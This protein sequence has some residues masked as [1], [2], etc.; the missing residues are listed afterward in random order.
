MKNI[1]W[2]KNL[3]FFGVRPG[4]KRISLLLKKLSHPH[5]KLKVIHL[6]GTNGKGSTA[7]IISKILEEHGFKVGLYTSPHLIKINERFLINDVPVSDEKLDFY[8]GRIK[9]ALG[10]DK[11]TYFEVTT[12]L[13]FLYFA[14]EKVDFAVIECGMGGRLD[15][16]NVLWPEVSVITTIGFDHQKFLGNTLDKIA[17]EKAG[18]M[19]RGVPCV[20]GEEKEETLHV[21][22][23]KAE[24]SKVPIFLFKKDFQIKLKNK[25]WYYFG[26]KVFKELDLSLQGFYQ[27]KNLAC[28][29]KT[30]E[31]LEDKGLFKIDENAL[32]DALKK[33]KNPGRYEKFYIKNK[34]IILD[35]AHNP[36]GI[37]ALVTSLKKDNFCKFIL[38][39]GI[40]NPY[41]DKD[42]LT[43][44]E[45]FFH[46]A[47]QV[48]ICE[49]TS[50]RKIVTL[51]EW[52][53]ALINLQKLKKISFFQH[54]EEAYK[55]ALSQSE[56]KILITGSI[57]FITHWLK[58][59]RNKEKN[60]LT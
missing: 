4:L 15:A 10:G 26:K 20:I 11:V 49:F 1:N 3:N 40:T 38:I 23:T 13:A 12:S 41:G 14:E 43:M 47:S 19:K 18:I 50:P 2:L 25:K 6:A 9:E 16:T 60:F 48:Y 56:Q 53:K 7:R 55:K 22:R 54:P 44:L 52:K 46:L 51:E 59:F 8:L 36:Q 31:V 42:F 17:R 45:K 29:I 5:R 32:K 27:G 37:E 21:F 28:A 39:M 30:L 35:A 33:V 34:E 57:Y 58:F 24:K